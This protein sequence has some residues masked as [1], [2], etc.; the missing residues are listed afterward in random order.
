[1]T[2]LMLL[3]RVSDFLDIHIYILHI[4][5]IRYHKYKEINTDLRAF[6]IGSFKHQLITWIVI[7]PIGRC[8]GSVDATHWPMIM[9][10]LKS[11]PL[12]S[13]RSVQ[14]VADRNLSFCHF[15][16]ALWISLPYLSL[17]LN[18]HIFQIPLNYLS[19][20]T[21]S[22]SWSWSCYIGLGNLSRL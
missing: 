20:C 13:R 6:L 14:S 16:L 10:Q 21:W 3:I 9:Y 8:I 4:L 18:L 15:V 12:A 5:I 22:W 1:M 17:F 7:G 19:L 11:W 2:Q